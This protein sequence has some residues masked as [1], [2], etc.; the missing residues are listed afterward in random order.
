M[1]ATVPT[2]IVHYADGSTVVSYAAAVDVPDSLAVGR[3]VNSDGYAIVEFLA[4]ASA[5]LDR[6]LAGSSLKALLAQFGLVPQGDCACGEHA[7]EMDR[8]G[9]DWSEQNIST[10]VSW[11]REEATKRGL[12]FVDLAGTVLVRR[13]IS[14]A[15]RLHRGKAHG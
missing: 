9:C 5:K 6:C 10:I 3:P 7:A 1:K 13:A 2:K 4:Y 14:N 12:P 15:R 11:L 8:N